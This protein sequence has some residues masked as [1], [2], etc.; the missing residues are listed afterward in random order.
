MQL[1]VLW[2]NDLSEKKIVFLISSSPFS[3]LKNYEALRSSLS[4]FDHQVS[5]IWRNDATHFTKN[6]VDKTMTKAILRLAEDMDIELYV[7]ENDLMQKG[8]DSKLIEPQIR[9]INND[10]LISILAS[11]DIVMN[12]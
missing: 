8:I 12:F 5:V 9:P 10:T 1:S 7:V 3:T 2:G 11:A 6:A 4:L